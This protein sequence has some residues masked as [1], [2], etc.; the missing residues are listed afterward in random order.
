MTRL[1][2]LGFVLAMAAVLVLQ[3]GA[4]S[5]LSQDAAKRCAAPGSASWP[6]SGTRILSAYP[7]IAVCQGTGDIERAENFACAEPGAGAE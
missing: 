1:A 5:A 3:P 6:D 4:A 7:K 2:N